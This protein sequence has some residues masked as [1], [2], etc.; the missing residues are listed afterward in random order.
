[1]KKSDLRKLIREEILCEYA[2]DSPRKGDWIAIVS[3]ANGQMV[4]E[5]VAKG[6]RK[7]DYQRQSPEVKLIAIVE[8]KDS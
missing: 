5:P 1:M 3:G 2:W 7:T 4:F 8:V 6:T